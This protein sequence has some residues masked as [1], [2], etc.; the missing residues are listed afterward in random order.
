MASNLNQEMNESQNQ[1]TAEEFI[2]NV[3][4]YNRE[5]LEE[6]IEESL[7]FSNSLS[8]ALQS[9]DNPDVYEIQ[10]SIVI[11]KLRITLAGVQEWIN[12]NSGGGTKSHATNNNDEL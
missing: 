1:Q 5:E 3:G 9:I 7:V 6:L 8:I 2:E 10:T 11:D 4:K 12:K